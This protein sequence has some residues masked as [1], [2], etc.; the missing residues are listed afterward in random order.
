MLAL[1]AAGTVLVDVHSVLVEVHNVL[2]EVRITSCVAIRWEV[3][4]ELFVFG[5]EFGM[6]VGSVRLSRER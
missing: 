4:G 1:P 5:C 2:V 6:L 3:I